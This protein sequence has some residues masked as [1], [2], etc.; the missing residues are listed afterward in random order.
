MWYLVPA[1]F[2]MEGVTKNYCV[3]R[4]RLELSCFYL[5]VS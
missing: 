3:M 1:L 4:D 5:E 2:L